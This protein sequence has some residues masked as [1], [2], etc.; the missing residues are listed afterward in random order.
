ME[1]LIGGGVVLLIFL[2][3]AGAYFVALAKGMSH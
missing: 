3:L 1:Y 2:V